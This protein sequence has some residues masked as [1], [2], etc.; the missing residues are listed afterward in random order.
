MVAAVRVVHRGEDVADVA[1][2]RE[3][4][5]SARRRFERARRRLPR[6]HRRRQLPRHA[7]DNDHLQ[8]CDGDAIVRHAERCRR[9]DL[10]AGS[11]S[12]HN[13]FAS[14]HAAHVAAVDDGDRQVVRREGD[15]TADV[16]P[17]CGEQARPAKRRD[18]RRAGR[19]VGH[20]PRA[21]RVCW[22]AVNLL[23]HVVVEAHTELEREPHVQGRSS[24]RAVFA[25]GHV[26][27]HL[28]TASAR[29]IQPQRAAGADGLDDG[30]IAR[31]AGG[32]NLWLERLVV[33]IV[34]RD[35]AYGGVNRDAVKHRRVHQRPLRVREGAHHA[36]ALDVKF[37]DHVAAAAQ[38]IDAHGLAADVRVLVVSH[39]GD[40]AG[41]GVEDPARGCDHPEGQRRQ[42]Q[43]RLVLHVGVWRLA[44]GDA[45]PREGARYVFGGADVQ[46]AALLPDEREGARVVAAD[47]P[48][49][50]ERVPRGAG[51]RADLHLYEVAVEP[52]RLRQA[53]DHAGCLER[54]RGDLGPQQRAAGVGAVD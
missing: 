43:A 46:R 6:G 7:C 26:D 16:Q 21:A 1:L 4:L 18:G 11:G 5:L 52:R 2:R 38:V 28:T 10:C 35:G 31:R 34:Q 27:G 12:S 25:A 19:L 17:L 49:P 30:G 9:V 37:A 15:E 32:S 29:G 3:S 39:L 36:L 20:H 13:G 44:L 51:V 47:E 24:A 41:E 42:P 48:P 14:A 54:R 23:Q 22:H 40:C 50:D 8:R 53:R 45:V 33:A